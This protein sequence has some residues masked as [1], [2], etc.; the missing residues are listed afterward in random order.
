M[1]SFLDEKKVFFIVFEELSFGD[2]IRNSRH[3]FYYINQNNFAVL[4]AKQNN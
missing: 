3:K 1:K 4:F 2:K